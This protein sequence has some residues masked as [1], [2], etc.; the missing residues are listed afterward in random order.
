MSGFIEGENRHQATLFP[1]SLDEY[2]VEVNPVRVVDVFVDSLDLSGVGFVTEARD[3]G[4]P[5]Y[6]PE[7]MLKLYIYGYLNKVQ[8][9]RRLKRESQRNVELIWLLN[10]LRSDFRKDDPEAIRSVCKQFVLF[11]RKLNLLADNLV[12]IDGSKFKAVN[13]RDKYFIKAKLEL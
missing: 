2:V 8:S 5:R 1:E 7:T 3:L 4:R 10:R 12:A 9:S 6:H 13:N 11:C